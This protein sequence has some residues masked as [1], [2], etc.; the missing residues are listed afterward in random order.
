MSNIQVLSRLATVIS[1]TPIYQNSIKTISTTVKDTVKDA[2][3]I[4]SSTKTI[5]KELPFSIISRARMINIYI[6]LPSIDTNNLTMKFDM[7]ELTIFTQKIKPYDL[8]ETSAELVNNCTYGTI[9]YK[10]YI[11]TT[12]T[13]EKDISY[14]YNAGILNIEIKK[15]KVREP[16]IIQCKNI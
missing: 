10:I 2:K 7:N 12:V 3:K 14:S 16:I 8:N 15:S 4:I 9:E 6:E 13:K 11:P 1:K 5:N